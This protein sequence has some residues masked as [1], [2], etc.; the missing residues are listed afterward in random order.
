M[1][2]AWYHLLL[3]VEAVAAAVVHKPCADIES[4]LSCDAYE[5]CKLVAKNNG[6]RSPLLHVQEASYNDS[7]RVWSMY[8]SKPH[9]TL[10]VVLSDDLPVVSLYEEESWA[11][12][13]TV[14]TMRLCR[15]WN[16]PRKYDLHDS[17]AIVVFLAGMM[18]G[19]WTYLSCTCIIHELETRSCI[20]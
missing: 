11:E 6:D 3:L 7:V 8:Q 16:S 17:I 1:R 9:G 20:G 13:G 19:V 12:F 14:V 18:A 5:V 2:Y 15:E 10:A 4:F